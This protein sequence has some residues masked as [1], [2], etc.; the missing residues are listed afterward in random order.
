MRAFTHLTTFRGAAELATWLTRIAI[1][2]AL[3]RLRRR[4]PRADLAELE[5]A[6]AD[7]TRVIPFP[8]RPPV[9]RPRPAAPRLAACSSSASTRC[10]GR[11]ASCSSCATS[12]G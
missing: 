10:P 4:R 2:E 5:A 3:G 7:D 12:R 8:R 11:C 1:N 6:G 9:P